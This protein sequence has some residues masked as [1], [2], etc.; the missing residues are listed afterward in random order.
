MASPPATMPDTIAEI[1]SATLSEAVDTARV[2]AQ[3]QYDNLV[4]SIRR[5]PL[6]AAFVAAGI[7][8]AL[9]TLARLGSR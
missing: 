6:Q 5:N 1:A 9:A 4:A 2:A 3:E 7:G 8:F